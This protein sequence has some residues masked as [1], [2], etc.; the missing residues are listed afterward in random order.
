MTA[1]IAEKDWVRIA[2]MQLADP[3]NWS[4]RNYSEWVLRPLPGVKPWE[5]A[6]RA[7]A[8]LDAGL[9]TEREK[10]WKAGQVAFQDALAHAAEKDGKEYISVQL[11][12]AALPL[13]LPTPEPEEPPFVRIEPGVLSYPALRGYCVMDPDG[14]YYQ[15]NPAEHALLADYLKKARIEKEHP[16]HENVTLSLKMALMPGMLVL[17]RDMLKHILIGGSWEM[18]PSPAPFHGTT[19]GTVIWRWLWRRIPHE[20]RWIHEC[21]CCSR[22]CQFCGQFEDSGPKKDRK[23]R[24]TMS[25]Q[26]ALHRMRWEMRS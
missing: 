20:C 1:P 3:K 8:A 9:A 18:R 17:T 7:L 6:G 13:P 14:T 11:V 23:I 15:P 10:W 25:Q 5:E 21:D 4:A 22:V 16:A 26:E 24:V 19:E 2:L 12:R